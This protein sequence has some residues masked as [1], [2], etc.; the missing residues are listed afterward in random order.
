M[1]RARP[2]RA[3]VVGAAVSLVILAGLF[4]AAPRAHGMPARDP[5]T[6]PSSTAPRERTGSRS[7]APAAVAGR[8]GY[9]LAA[10]DGSVYTFGASYAGSWAGT[11]LRAPV[12]ATASTPHFG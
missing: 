3:L 9:R 2:V 7:A 8:P 5:A 10:T 1:P 4:G 12:I 6:A 11:P